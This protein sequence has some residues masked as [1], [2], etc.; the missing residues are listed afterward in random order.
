M[1]ALSRIFDVA[2]PYDVIMR[3]SESAIVAWWE[4]GLVAKEMME[5]GVIRSA[6][7]GDTE[8]RDQSQA[9]SGGREVLEGRRWAEY[10]L[11]PG[12]VRPFESRR[13]MELLGKCIM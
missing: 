8:K 5:N 10:H 3:G 11:T 1:V 13:G 12:A 4:S 7:D 9:E 6:L 2:L